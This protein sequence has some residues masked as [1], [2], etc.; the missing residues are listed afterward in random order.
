MTDH[1]QTTI[2]IPSAIRFGSAKIEVKNDDGDFV[3]LGAIKGLSTTTN[4][5]EATPYEP[6]NAPPMERDSTF[7]SWDVAFTMEEVWAP[8]NWKLL[9]GNSDT[10]TTSSTKTTIGLGAGTSERPYREVRITNTTPGEAPAVFTLPKVKYTGELD[11]SFP[12]DSDKAT[13]LGLPITLRAY[14]TGT[15]WGTLEIPNVEPS[16]TISP[17]TV[18]VAIDGTESISVTGGN[19]VTFGILNANVATIS[20]SGVVTGVSVGSTYALVTVDG[21]EFRVAVEVSE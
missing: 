17:Q 11:L 3:D 1:Y 6:D 14:P 10:Y 12:A 18:N 7:E 20:S 9:R 8:E 19:V 2:Q 5:K 21:S 4:V 16:I 13:A 15:G